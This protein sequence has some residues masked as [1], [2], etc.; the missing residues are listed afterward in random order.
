MLIL[1]Q[2]KNKVILLKDTGS[3][4]IK[5]SGDI[6]EIEKEDSTIKRPVN[7]N[8]IITENGVVHN[9]GTFTELEQA[10]EAMSD[11]AKC[12]YHEKLTM[13]KIMSDNGKNFSSYQSELHMF[14]IY[15]IS[16][17]DPDAWRN[18]IPATAR[19]LGDYT[20]ETNKRSKKFDWKNF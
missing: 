11:I 18:F 17:D 1:S 7:F 19:F 10:K 14:S 12:V 16:P 9:V 2:D 8:L 13:A 15:N 3:I 5:H 6:E 20:E 4:E